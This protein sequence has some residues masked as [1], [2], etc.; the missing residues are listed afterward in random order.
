MKKHFAM[1]AIAALTLT[2]S[3]VPAWGADK[4]TDTSQVKLQSPSMP[5]LRQSV[6]SAAG[7][8]L[9]GVELKSTAHQVTVTIANS[10]KN[11]ETAADREK[12]ALAMASALEGG[13]AGKPEFE[14]VASI[15]IDYISRLGKKVKT[16][17]VFD[18]FRS[19][20][21]AFVLHKT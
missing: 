16:I 15:H 8:Q 11:D 17:Q 14:G 4:V 18:L 5:V 12:E 9:K 13:M 3:L 1:A 21:N 2:C 20:A 6:A 7:Y 10:K 19:P